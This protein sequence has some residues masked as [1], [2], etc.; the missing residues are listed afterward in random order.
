MKHTVC[1]IDDK[2]PVAQYGDFF[3]DTDIIS[4]SV[5]KYL[6]K[7]KDTDWTGDLVVK[8]MCE[9][10][11]NEPERWTVSAFTSPKFYDNYTKDTVYAPEI[12]IYDWDYNFGSDESEKHLLEILESSYTMIFECFVSSKTLFT[13]S[14]L[15]FIS[16]A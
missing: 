16:T 6:L 12:V 3:N 13:S 1:F 8:A 14:M 4:S 2:I 11:I 9:K 10:L 5:I 7:Q 15:S